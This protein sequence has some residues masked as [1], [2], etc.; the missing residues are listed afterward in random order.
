MAKQL[1]HL[2]PQMMGRIPPLSLAGFSSVIKRQ[3]AYPWMWGM[4]KISK[5][6]WYNHM[7]FDEPLKIVII[8]HKKGRHQFASTPPVNVH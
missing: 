4:V 5:K 3:P 6:I 2:S 8:F 7:S 1:C